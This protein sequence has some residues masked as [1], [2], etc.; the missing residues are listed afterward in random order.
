[1][2]WRW[3]VPGRLEV[4]GKHTDYAG[5]RT[6]VGAVPKGITVSAWPTATNQVIVTDVGRV[7]MERIATGRPAPESPPHAD[8]AV[9][10]VRD[11]GPYH[12]WRRYVATVITRLAR[13]FP[14][15]NLSC[16]I[17]FQSTLPR[18]A[19]ISSS[20]ALVTAIAEVLIARGEIENLPLWRET[21]RTAED[22][23]AYFACIEN[24]AAFGP[25]SG[26][27]GVGTHGG[28]EDHAAIL[29]SRAGFLQQLSFS[30]LQR[31]RLVAMPACWTFVV[32]S[33]GIRARKAGEVRYNYNLAAA[34]AA[35]IVSLW[36]ER[37]PQDE[38]TLAQLAREE[39]LATL[40][41]SSDLRSRLE[42]F[43]REDRRVVEAGDAFARGDVAAIG[44]LSDAS[45]RDA[46]TLLRNQVPETLDLVA[47]AR[48]EGAAAACGFGA[49]WGGSV[50]ALVRSDEAEAFLERW[51]MAFEARHPNL[52]PEGFLS[53]PS[54]GITRL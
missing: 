21:I 18:A 14:E 25:L 28:S 26:D 48:A 32:A 4:F 16:T 38:R 29:M 46:T 35:A 30:P 13:N 36:R 5:G 1:M 23:A 2:K 6:L 12:G 17:E 9:F 42:H 45:Q 8:S 52:V 54:D 20:S 40:H 22:R 19:G 50:W 31:D 49:G 11:C 44:E 51:L 53:P 15:A 37:Y 3:F 24:G 7:P 41:L 43:V 34:S 39:P 27:A 10:P 47:D 33:T